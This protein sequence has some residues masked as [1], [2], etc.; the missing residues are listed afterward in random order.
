VGVPRR[1]DEVTRNRQERSCDI[2][3]QS[4]VHGVTDSGVGVAVAERGL[5]RTVDALETVRQLG[6]VTDRL[7]AGEAFGAR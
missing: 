5:R 3:E 1:G 7:F 2:G 6:P 4:C